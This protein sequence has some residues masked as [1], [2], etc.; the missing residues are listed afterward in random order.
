MKFARVGPIGQEIPVVVAGDILYDLR[1]LTS[2]IDGNFLADLDVEAV[3]SAMG[4]GQLP[5][6]EADSRQRLGSPIRRP[7]AIYCV[8]LN[9][10]G[11]AKESGAEL[12]Q[13]PVMFMKPPN[14]LVGPFDQVEIPK[15]STKTDW[16]VELG[17]VIGKRCSYLDSPEQSL[18]HVAGFVLA[19]DLSERDFQLEMSGGQWSKGKSSPGFTP[20]GPWLVTPEEVNHRALRLQS[21]VNG[22]PRQD[23][24][25]SDL[26]FGVEQIIFHLSQFLEFEPGDLILTGTPEGVALSGRF[27]FLSPGD[28][29][30]LNIEGLGASR[31]EMLA[32][33]GGPR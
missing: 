20:V 27:P 16:E 19:N 26:V 8:G 24:S 29:V 3:K 32:Y 6:L 31:Q 13:H 22:E 28:I 12:P 33:S 15:N 7:S 1:L 9:Y 17:V 23:S 4:R 21:F 11:H 10:A 30:D 18:D 25:T 5:A 14:T 2:D